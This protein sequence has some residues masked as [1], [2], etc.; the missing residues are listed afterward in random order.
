MRK[1]ESPSNGLDYPCPG[2][3]APGTEKVAVFTGEGFL[4]EK[5]LALGCRTHTS[6]RVK[7]KLQNQGH[8]GHELHW[9]SR[10]QAGLAEDRGWWQAGL[11]LSQVLR[12]ALRGP[13]HT[14]Y[15]TQETEVAVR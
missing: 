10:E 14:G 12:R 15:R 1:K 7:E 11:V 5:R 6:G 2:L 13:L 9:E 8:C 3:W 4:E